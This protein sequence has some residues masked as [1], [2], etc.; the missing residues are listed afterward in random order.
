MQ[1][2]SRSKRVDEREGQE[3]EHLLCPTSPIPSSAYHYDDYNYDLKGLKSCTEVAFQNTWSVSGS[4]PHM[5][6]AEIR[7]EKIRLDVICIVHTVIK[8][9][10]HMWAKGSDFSRSCWHRKHYINGTNRICDL[11]AFGFSQ[12]CTHTLVIFIK[13]VAGS[14]LWEMFLGTRIAENPWIRNRSLGEMQAGVIKALDENCDESG[15]TVLDGNISTLT[16]RSM[17]S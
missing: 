1:R 13:V 7:F 5:E 17:T 10:S 15:R 6:E 12:L 16:R 8:N 4:E 2:H 3:C 14:R 11:I 9:L